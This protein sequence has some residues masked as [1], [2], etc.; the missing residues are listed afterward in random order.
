MVVVL[1]AGTA[2]VAVFAV[3]QRRS[4]LQPS[5]STT[6]AKTVGSAGGSGS[7]VDVGS[8][9]FV[10][11]EPEIVQPFRPTADDVKAMLAPSFDEPRLLEV[12]QVDLAPG[13]DGRHDVIA[14]KL[15]YDGI[16]L[17]SDVRS[18]SFNRAD[19]VTRWHP[20]RRSPAR[21]RRADALSDAAA[22]EH[23]HVAASATVHRIF[24][25]NYVQEWK[26]SAHT[27]ENEVLAVGSFTAAIEVMGTDGYGALIDAYSGDVIRKTTTWID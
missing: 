2:L 25:A 21:W 22:R 16:E 19:W 7:A 8:Q 23:A 6:N 17:D 1:I 26:G 5:P 20:I 4:Q 9:S 10:D 15:R 13:R 27:A 24:Q 14:W 18:S 3:A 11:P 12:S